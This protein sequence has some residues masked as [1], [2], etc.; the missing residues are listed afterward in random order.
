MP[1]SARKRA[2]AVSRAR[3]TLPRRRRVTTSQVIARRGMILLGIVVAASLIVALVGT[4]ASNNQGSTP[5]STPSR[6]DPNELIRAATAN[7][8]DSDTVGALADYYNNTG[9]YQ[10]ALVTFQRY[11]LL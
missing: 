11:L 1:S 10:L 9:Q 3:T 7:P 4:V 2:R 6:S 8:T 5:L